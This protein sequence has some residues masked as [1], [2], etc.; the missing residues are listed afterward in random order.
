MENSKF[1]YMYYEKVIYK[2]LSNGFNVCNYHDHKTIEKPC[3]LRHDV[4]YDVHKAEEFATFE[5]SLGKNISSTYF[6]LL[7]SDFYNVFSLKTL[8]AIEHII[9]LGHEV[10]LHFDET[11]YSINNDEGLYK[12]FVDEE[13]YLLGKALGTTIRVVSMHRPSNYTLER[14]LNFKNAVNSYSDEF[15]KNFKYVSDSRMNWKEDIISI[16]EQNEFKKLHLLTHPFWYS[17]RIEDTK[18][19][20]VKFINEAINE[21]YQ[22]LSD[23]FRDLCEFVSKGDLR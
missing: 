9:S 1:T 22:N 19:K 12:E 5:S 3:I 21:R 4:D 23:N 2:I 8:R 16:V 10:G 7:T 20:L 15:F 17:E 6:F 14:N 18:E 11:K 13:L